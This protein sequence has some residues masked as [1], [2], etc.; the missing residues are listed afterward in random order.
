LGVALGE[1]F[2]V[3]ASFPSGA[4]AISSTQVLP[5]AK[6]TGFPAASVSVI[7]AVWLVFAQI[8]ATHFAAEQ[9]WASPVPIM[10]VLGTL[11]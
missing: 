8:A 4:A 6:S 11:L 9:T 5:G 10:V 1:G 7:G 3:K 2:R